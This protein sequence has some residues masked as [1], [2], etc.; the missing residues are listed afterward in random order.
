MISDVAVGIGVFL[1]IDKILVDRI[2]LSFFVN[3]IGGFIIYFN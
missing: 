2:S 3:K 1:G